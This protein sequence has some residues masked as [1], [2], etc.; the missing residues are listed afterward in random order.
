MTGPADLIVTGGRVITVDPS[1][2]IAEAVAIR[3]DKIIAVG[4][5]TEIADLAVNNTQIIDTD[6]RAIIPGLIDAHAHM[7]REGLK[8]VFPTLAGCESIDDVLQRVEA[9]VAKAEPGAWVVTMPIGEPPYYF[10][11]PGNLRERT[12]RQST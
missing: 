10:D 9:L 3:D 6:G 12:S 8:P 5:T 7:D 11:V 4:G 1:F 2:S